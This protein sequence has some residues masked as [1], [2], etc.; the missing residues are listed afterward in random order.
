MKGSLEA[1]D[2]KLFPRSFVQGYNLL[3][4]WQWSV[5]AAQNTTSATRHSA[6]ESF[7]AR[8]Q[9]S[10]GVIR[11]GK[12][13]LLP[14]PHAYIR[15]NADRGAARA[16]LA[17]GLA[18]RLSALEKVFQPC[19]R[20]VRSSESPDSGTAHRTRPSPKAQTTPHRLSTASLSFTPSTCS[21]GSMVGCIRLCI[22]WK[23]ST[24][25]P[26]LHSGVSFSHFCA[27][28][29]TSVRLPRSRGYPGAYW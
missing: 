5:T 24:L 6:F 14:S 18:K 9:Q 22:Y 21:P 29:Q 28:D 1:E 7:Q 2:L 17:E 8:P 10:I 3:W 25:L 12:Q 16:A 4:S 27:S 20:R 23:A 13:D 11:Q 26:S 19:T 15:V